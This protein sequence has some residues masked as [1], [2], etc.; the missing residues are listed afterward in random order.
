MNLVQYQKTVQGRE[1]P[2]HFITTC[3]N[4]RCPGRQA[5]KAK[6]YIRKGDN[7]VAYCFH[8]GYRQGSG[9]DVTSSEADVTN[10]THQPCTIKD[11]EWVN[12]CHQLLMEDRHGRN[13]GLY[14]LTNERGLSLQTIK[15]A[16]LGYDPT[17][18]RITV[19]SFHEGR[20]YSI[21]GRAINPTEDE[22]KYIYLK[23]KP[24]YPYGWDDLLLEKDGS[25][26]NPSHLVLVEGEF[27][28]L[29]A[30]ELLGN[31]NVVAV[32]GATV[33][34]PSWL[35]LFKPFDRIYL[36]YDL[37]ADDKVL[38]YV[39]Q[40]GDYRCHIVRVPKEV[41]DINELLTR[42][43]RDEAVK[44]WKGCLRDAKLVGR[45]LLA[46]VGDYADTA[47][48]V[49]ENRNQTGASTGFPALDQATGG[50]NAG[51]V[52]LL[53]GPAKR[54]KTSLALT[55]MLNIARQGKPVM[56]GSFEMSPEREM[57]PRILSILNK[58]NLEIEKN[59]LGQRPD[60]ERE[61][62]LNAFYRNQVR[63][64]DEWGRLVF[65]NRHD[66]IRI[67]EIEEAVRLGYRDGARFVLLD[68]AQ[69][70]MSFGTDEIFKATAKIS[71]LIK[72][73]TNDYPELAILMISE[74][75]GYEPKGNSK[76]KQDTRRVMGG[77]TLIYDSNQCWWMGPPYC[78]EGQLI[79]KDV[80][81]STVKAGGIVNI[82][83]D[84]A[85]MR[86]E[87]LS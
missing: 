4:D 40:L 19:P 36:R 16:R 50:L 9:S 8:C 61:Q 86:T 57:I 23:G 13:V 80:R 66:R 15:N 42:Y 44:I 87:V 75:S 59:E 12:Q 56:L 54:G 18:G 48:R 1:T 3:P 82:Y 51:G 30:R 81:D 67:S 14:Y 33:F 53:V 34:K 6:F 52:Y 29:A 20:L 5:G 84:Q 58:R 10:P 22:P 74:M 68:H 39:K 70:M 24:I 21:K 73:L 62:Q 43:P 69:F 55:I 26:S 85:T 11:E 32:C 72:R 25:F 27:D 37:D 77:D 76:F 46:T 64:L 63:K 17:T 71:R 49:F 35:R 78:E 47:I 79:V 65:I 28:C 45:P 60:P 38:E 7:P 41:K 31:T 2:T 83:F